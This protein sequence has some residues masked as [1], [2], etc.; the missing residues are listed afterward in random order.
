MRPARSGVTLIELL[1]IIVIIGILAAIALPRFRRT[2]ERAYLAAVQS[3]IRS[4]ATQQELYHDIHLAYAGDTGQ[5]ADFRT[6][7]GVTVQI[8]AAT[9]DGWAATA[10]HAGLGSRQC[11]LYYGTAAASSAPPADRPGV[12]ACN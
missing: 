10:N 9:T 12:I 3:D 2:R 4:C 8:T 5:L 1:V 6:T 7:S 11:G